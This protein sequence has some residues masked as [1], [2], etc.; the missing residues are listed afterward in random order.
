MSSHRPAGR[1]YRPRHLAG[2]EGA[3]VAAPVPAAGTDG[4]SPDSTEP[5]SAPPGADPLETPPADPTALSEAPAAPPAPAPTGA[6]ARMLRSSAIMAAGSIVSR[7]L[8]FVRNFLFG[9]MT[10]GAGTVAGNAYSAANQLPD[11]IWILV[12]G[13]VLNAVLVPAIVRATR[14]A[15]RGSDFVSRLM[16][17]VVLV[18][19]ILTAVCIALV[20]ILVTVTNGSLPPATYVLAVQMGFFL[21]PQ[22]IFSAL[23]VMCG[24][25]LNAHNSFGPYEW[26][27]VMN[28]VVGIIGAL[29]FLALWG[30][31]P[32]PE[33]WDLGRVLLLATMNVGGS[34]AQVGFLWYFVR[35]L[36]LRLRPRWGFRGLGLGKLSR[37]G[38]WTLAMV[39]VGQV[40][41]FAGRW[42]TAGA[43]RAAEHY[44]DVG[45]PDLAAQYP[46]LLSMNWAYM[47]FM[48]PQGVIAVT[49]VTTAFPSISRFAAD[50]DH[51]SALRR[52]AETSRMLAVPMVLCT[53]VFAALCVPIMWVIGGG[54]GPTGALANGPV[55]AAY[56]LGLVPF[57]ATY[58]IKRVFYAYEDARAPFWMQLP[59]TAVPLLAVLPILW[60]VDPRWATAAAALAAAL[61]NMLGW[62]CG[63][64]LLGRR[65]QALG[66][67][68]GTAG[69]TLAT[70]L[71]LF[72]AG[73]IAFAVGLGLWLLLEDVFFRHRLVAIL[74]GAAVGAV[75]TALFAGIAWAL[76]VEELRSVTAVV[77]RR[78]LKR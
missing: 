25:L 5:E 78:L 54:S 17:L 48:I 24:Q 44:G 75:M 7:L 67:G 33:D 3:T 32:G 70:Y 37:I 76:R 20:P 65:K 71:K 29:I 15:D 61:G 12:G 62:A 11:S 26:A 74:L 64:W 2:G 40:G 45:R 68:E 59:T 10:A 14:Q 66:A 41:V 8:G 47:A 34:V 63:M 30:Q 60:W 13:G 39:S 77:R 28:N 52:Y 18:A 35:K 49:L 72:L 73:G 6:R 19:S 43:S 46:A 58:L 1:H 21:M 51:P 38:L 27:S 69:R 31:A 55:L 50:G 22:I 42:S 16:T 56:M 57:S 4:T 36:G 53:A 9:V 23:Y